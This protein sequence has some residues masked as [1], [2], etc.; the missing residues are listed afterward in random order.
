MADNS[1][2]DGSDDQ[3]SGGNQ[4]LPDSQ[5]QTEAEPRPNTTEENGSTSQSEPP[6][7]DSSSTVEG[8]DDLDKWAESQ[9]IDLENPTSEQARKLA[10][11]VRDTQK[12]MHDKANQAKGKEELTK[13]IDELH[14]PSKAENAEDDEYLKEVRRN[15][16]ETAQL[17]AQVRL[18]NFYR[19]E[20]DA[21]DYEDDMKEVLIREVREYGEEAGRSLAQNMPRL[22]REAKAL[23]GSDYD[24]EAAREAGR[25]EEREQLRRRQEAGV[26]A[27]SAQ[28]PRA[29]TQ[30]VNRRWIADEYDPGNKEH[31]QMLDEAMARGPIPD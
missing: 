5:S 16:M 24:A 31:V 21:Q 13:T 30:K 15:R 20:P 4:P 2:P 22:L 3:N 1:I 29:R 10:K 12:A 23:R 7:G 28:Q 6:K 11:R 27:A 19:D 9:G 17:R 25:R 18:Q 14:D 8:S 26:D